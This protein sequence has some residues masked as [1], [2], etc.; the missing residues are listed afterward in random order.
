MVAGEKT[1]TI[2]RCG[3]A[4]MQIHS[5]RSSQGKVRIDSTQLW[6]KYQCRISE[7]VWRQ[8]ASVTQRNAVSDR[9]N[10][11]RQQMAKT[12]ICSRVQAD[13]VIN[14][15][16]QISSSYSTVREIR[17]SKTRQCICQNATDLKDKC[18][19]AE[20]KEITL[21]RGMLMRTTLLR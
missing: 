21:W 14:F 7:R 8:K 6:R 3:G 1:D 17:V 18:L 5:S 19:Q 16:L 2:Y 4:S 13:T 15:W 20:L 11:P 10:Q 9:Y 12:K